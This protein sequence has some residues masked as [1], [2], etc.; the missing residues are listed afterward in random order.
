MR[1]KSRRGGRSRPSRRSSDSY[2]SFMASPSV[3]DRDMPNAED[4][5]LNDEFVSGQDACNAE[6]NA[7]N[8]ASR[9]ET[10]D[11]SDKEDCFQKDI[12]IRCDESGGL[13][14]CTEIGCPIALHE[15][16]MSCKPS[17]DEEGRFYCPYC[18]Y[19][20]ALVIVNE[21]RR[22]AMA[23]KRKLSDFIDNRMVSG[24]NSPQ[25]GEAGKKKVTEVSTCGVDVDLPN[26]ESSR[27]QEDMQVGQNRSN[28]GE[29]HAR[30]AGDVQL[31]TV[32]G[33]NSK[34][35][36]GPSVSSVSNGIHST[37]EVQPC[38]DAMNE[39]GTHQ[40][41]SLEDKEDGKTMEEENFRFTDDIEDKEIVKDQ[42]QPKIPNDE[43]ETAVDDVDLGAGRASQDTGDGAE[44]IQ[45]ENIHPASG[46]NDLKNE[47]FVKK[48]RF[49]MKANR[50]VD[51]KD[52]NSPRMS[53]RRQTPDHGTKSPHMQTPKREKTSPHIQTPKPGKDRSTK[54]EKVSTSGKLKLKPA[55]PNQFKNLM[56]HGE[57]RKRMR[58]STEEE[59]MLKE[60]VQRFSSSVNKNLPWRKILEFGRHIFDDT[61]TPVDLK[62]KWRNIVDK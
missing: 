44:Q 17:F 35:H 19:K 59:D 1:T 41:E 48:K 6:D 25:L 55:S 14:V 13:L 28:Q 20:R 22:K 40:D 46:N 45:P 18:S 5:T 16:C 52:F 12:C 57:K 9:K 26:H 8:E 43:E 24:A 31:S 62:D 61:R 50:K 42:G 54:V 30:T 23:A 27:D 60:G 21:L 53:L 36:E 51:R 37:H 3:P 58:W 56:F 29:D 39:E 15:Y 7:L 4:K 47:T 32:M 33:V 49:K 38:E 2:P 10:H 11:V 34:N